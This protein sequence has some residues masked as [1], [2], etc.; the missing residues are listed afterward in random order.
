MHY[1][2]YHTWQPLG[3][4][5]AQAPKERLEL[6][7]KEKEYEDRGKIKANIKIFVGND[8]DDEI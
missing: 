6:E 5:I 4:R 8:F 2:Q 3:L 1:V 7:T